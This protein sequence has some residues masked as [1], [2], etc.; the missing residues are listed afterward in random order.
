MRVVEGVVRKN[1]LISPQD[2]PP[3]IFKIVQNTPEGSFTKP[4]NTGRGF[5]AYFVKSKSNSMSGNSSFELVK[6]QVEIRWLQDQRVKAM[7]DF[8]DKLRNSADIRIIR[9]P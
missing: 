1:Q 8:V 7:K 5:I 9:V 6:N 3:N 4:I 2:V